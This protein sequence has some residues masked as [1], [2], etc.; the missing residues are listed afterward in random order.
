MKNLFK[1]TLLLASFTVSTALFAQ[2]APKKQDDKKA[3]TEVKKD[4]TASDSTKTRMAITEQG[5]PKKNKNKK[6]AAAAP[7]PQKKNESN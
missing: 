1:V 7:A 3:K 2:E 6:A 4:T 5:T